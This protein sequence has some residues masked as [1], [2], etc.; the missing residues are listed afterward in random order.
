LLLFV[1]EYPG[2]TDRMAENGTKKGFTKLVRV[3]F[4]VETYYSK[5]LYLLLNILVIFQKLRQAFDK[6]SYEKDKPRLLLSAA[7]GAAKHRIDE[8]YE[9][10]EICKYDLNRSRYLTD[11]YF[12]L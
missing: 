12:Q 3:G 1:K 2:A 10:D 5:H 4:F 6:E 8:G 11:L 9:V 7:V